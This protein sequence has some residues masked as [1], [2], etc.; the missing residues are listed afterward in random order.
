MSSDIDKALRYDPKG[1]MHQRRIQMNFKGYDVKH[2]EVLDALAN[3]NLLEQV[4]L[5]NGSSSNGDQSN[6]NQEAIKQL[7]IPTPLKVEKSLKR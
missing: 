2:D 5:G 4:E 1:I 6:Q 3:T 7:E